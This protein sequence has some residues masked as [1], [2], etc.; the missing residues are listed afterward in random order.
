[1]ERQ[2]RCGSRQTGGDMR[3]FS[4]RLAV[5]LAATVEGAAGQEATRRLDLAEVRVTEPRLARAFGR[6]IDGSPSAARV[7]GDLAESGLPLAIGRPADLAGLPDAQGGPAPLERTALLAG[8]EPGRTESPARVVF[9]LGHDGTVERAWIAVDVDA[10]DRL[11][12]K[13]WSEEARERLDDDLLAT[14]AHEFV[15]HVGSVARTRRIA[16]FCDDPPVGDHAEEAFACSLRVENRVRSE[17]NKG[18]GLTGPRRL[19]RR[20]SYSFDVM[21]F[22]RGWVE[23]PAAR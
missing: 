23:R 4:L 7:L 22:S 12:R 18:L 17:L 13:G 16:D 21:N 15:A 5:A 19:P 11:E 14:L 2:R 20:Y 10:M 3:L 1:M 6:L 9:R 8:S